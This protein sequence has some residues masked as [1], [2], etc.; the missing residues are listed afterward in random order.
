MIATDLPQM[1][2]RSEVA[3]SL[4]VSGELVTRWLRDGRLPSTRTSLGR[5][6]RVEDVEQL[7]RERAGESVDAE[8]SGR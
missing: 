6:V 3:R 7:R 1:L 8:T 4:G 5:L 2:S